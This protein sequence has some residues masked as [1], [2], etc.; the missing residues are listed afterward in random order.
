MKRIAV[1]GSTGSIGRNTLNIIRAFPD[2]FS[3]AALSVNNNT[4]DLV[5][6]IKEFRPQQVCVNDPGKAAQLRKAAGTRVKVLC[7]PQGVEHICKSRDV[8]MVVLAISGSAALRPLLSAIDN[9]KEVAT[10]NKEALVMAGGI[11][12]KRAEK[13]GVRIIP[14]DSEQ[15]AIWQCLEGGDIAKLRRIYLTASGGPF[16]GF[17]RSRMKKITLKQALS[18]PR[19]K[20]GRKITVDS[21]T[22][23]NKGL[24]VLEAMALFGVGADKIK[25]VIHP[26]SIIHSMVEFIDGV[27]MA[28]L[29]ITDMRIPIQYALSYPDRLNSGLPGLDLI[30]TGSLNFSEPDTRGFPCLRMAYQAARKSG[31]YPC[32]LNAANEAAVEEFLKGKMD[33]ISIPEV[34]GRVLT[35]HKGISDPGIE[36]ILD[37]SDWARRISLEIAGKLRKAG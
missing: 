23:M 20:M 17:D 16:L 12:R 33:F 21:A 8:D 7:G 1:L 34:V 22:L 36:D 10:A 28:Q 30:K 26:E 24:E 31:T 2:K 25:V 6:Q 4:A 35:R 15:S 13:Y 11:V 9:K 14:I 3:A 18:H 32:V 37:S 19:W 27:V 5:R 29:S